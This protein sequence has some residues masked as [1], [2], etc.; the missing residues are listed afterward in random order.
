MLVQLAAE[1]IDGLRIFLSQFAQLQIHPAVVFS[2]G[3]A[4]P[5]YQFSE[6]L[7]LVSELF[8]RIVKKATDIDIGVIEL[9]F[10]LIGCEPV[11]QGGVLLRA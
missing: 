1:V 10:D 2:I 7:V 6:A 5:I 3:I 4:H 8:C 9:G 11:L